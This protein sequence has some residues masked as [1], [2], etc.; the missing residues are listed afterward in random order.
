MFGILASIAFAVGGVSS[1]MVLNENERLAAEEARAPIMS[2]ILD[3]PMRFVPL[4]Q[5]QIQPL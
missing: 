4:I 5:T 2:V 1:A 3:Q